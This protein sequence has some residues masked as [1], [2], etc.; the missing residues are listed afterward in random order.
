[1]NAF[2]VIKTVRLTEKG[3]RQG[4]KYNQYT[5]VADRRA[6]KTEIRQAVQEL[7]KVKV[8][9]VNTLNVRGKFRRQRTHAGRPGAELEKGHRDV[10]RRRQDCFDVARIGKVK[11]REKWLIFTPFFWRRPRLGR[12]PPRNG[13]FSNPFRA[14]L[15]N[16]PQFGSPLAGMWRRSCLILTSGWHWPAGFWPVRSPPR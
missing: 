3:T 4:E 6:N 2:E 11:R 15:A 14:E 12:Q 9:K 13:L 10:E 16:F 7:F 8:T 5:V 1:M